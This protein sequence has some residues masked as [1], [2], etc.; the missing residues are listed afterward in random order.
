MA[1][2]WGNNGNS[3]KLYFLR[4]QNY[5]RCVTAA[6]KLKNAWSLEEKLWPTRQ[7]IKKQRLSFAN[8]GPSSQSYGFSSVM[9]GCESW[10]IKKSEHLKI[11][12]F[13]LWCWRRFLRVPWTARRS[14][15]SILK[16]IK[17]EYVL[18]G[19]MNSNTLAT[20]C[21]TLTHW[22]RHWCW[23]RLKAGGK[24]D[25]R[26]LDVWMFSVTQWA[27]SL[28][29]LWELVMDR[30]AW[31]AAV[32]GVAKNGTRLSDGTA[33]CVLSETRMYGCW[34]ETHDFNCW[35]VSERNNSVSAIPCDMRR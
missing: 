22:K 11:D 26:E 16:E 13:E 18:E 10:T 12:V 4:L 25:D 32:H 31:C 8:K 21:Q 5:H 2:R 20:W 15:Q 23:E 17:P 29:K 27:L 33:W 7:H 9:Y 14:S 3:H 24:E 35:K 1:N 28:S 30:E 34:L 6:M 19:L